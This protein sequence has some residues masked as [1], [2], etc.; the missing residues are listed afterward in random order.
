M[1]YTSPICSMHASLLHRPPER[2]GG[3]RGAWSQGY[4]HACYFLIVN[5][6]RSIIICTGL[7]S[8]TVSMVS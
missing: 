5:V 3:V 8:Y 6:T 4:M 7:Q 1:Y 2:K